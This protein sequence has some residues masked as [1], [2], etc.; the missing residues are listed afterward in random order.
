MLG[1]YFF[2]DRTRASERVLRHPGNGHSITAYFANGRFA[3]RVQP[4]AATHS[5]SFSVDSDDLA[6]VYRFDLAQD[7]EMISPPFAI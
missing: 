6:R 2:L 1:P 3:R 4:I 5:A 7:S